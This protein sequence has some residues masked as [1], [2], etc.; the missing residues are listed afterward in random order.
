MFSQLINLVYA[1]VY[2]LCS[3]NNDLGPITICYYVLKSWL[4]GLRRRVMVP[5]H[6][7]SRIHERNS[8]HAISVNLRSPYLCRFSPGGPRLFS[9]VQSAET[10]AFSMSDQWSS[11]PRTKPFLFYTPLISSPQIRRCLST[12]RW[13]S[14]SSCVN[15]AAG[16]PTQTMIPSRCY[17]IRRH[18]RT[19]VVH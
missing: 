8:I 14:S 15:Y 13:F 19:I 2:L 16:R 18:C 10:L 7:P 5:R 12:H 3:S 4:N 6:R 17:E 1:V 9:Q 11:D